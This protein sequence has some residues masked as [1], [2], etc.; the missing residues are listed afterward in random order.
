M[1]IIRFQ[2]V[3]LLCVFSWPAAADDLVS[4]EESQRYYF[5]LMQK[6]ETFRLHPA[7]APNYLRGVWRLDRRAHVGGGHY[8]RADKGDDVALI[9]N[10]QRLVQMDFNRNDERS[11][12]FVGQLSKLTAGANG[13]LHFGDN[14]RHLMPL[15]LNHMA[16]AMYDYVAVLERV[17]G[18][19]NKSEP[20]AFPADEQR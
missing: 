10:D 18:P 7:A 16:V 19:P 20:M 4:E 17:S 15:D 5:S 12:E 3:F 11:V 6:A 2:I 1:N 14:K 13:S 8:V 9:C